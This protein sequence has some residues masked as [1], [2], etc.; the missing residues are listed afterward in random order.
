MSAVVII[1]LGLPTNIHRFVLS[2]SVTQTNKH[3]QL[4]IL[5]FHFTGVTEPKSLMSDTYLLLS[6]RCFRSPVA[7][8]KATRVPV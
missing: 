5:L 3:K 7:P 4:S 8:Q 6:C 2:C 1:K